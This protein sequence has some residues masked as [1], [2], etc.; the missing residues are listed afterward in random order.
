MELTFIHFARSNFFQT[1]Y[2]KSICFFV[3]LKISTEMLHFPSF[4]M[5]KSRFYDDIVDKKLMR[6]NS[7]CKR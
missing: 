4:S 7:P 3:F 6:S 2:V 1:F 5:S